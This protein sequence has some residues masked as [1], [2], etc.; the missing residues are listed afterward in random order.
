MDHVVMIFGAGKEAET[1]EEE[2]RCY[3]AFRRPCSVTITN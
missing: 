3:Q 1:K 2:T